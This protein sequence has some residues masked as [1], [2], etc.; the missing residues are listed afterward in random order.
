[1]LVENRVGD[2]AVLL[3]TLWEYPADEAVIDLTRELLRVDGRQPC[4]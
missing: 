4:A 3:V 1:V 2:G